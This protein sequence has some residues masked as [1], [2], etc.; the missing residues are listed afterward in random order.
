M[1]K[2]RRFLSFVL[3]SFLFA[4]TLPAAAIEL[5]TPETAAETTQVSAAASLSAASS[6]EMT[7]DQVELYDTTSMER[8]QL[9]FFS[10]FNNSE[11]PLAN[12]IED[13]SPIKGLTIMTNG[14]GGIE[15]IGG[16]TAFRSK[17]GGVDGNVQYTG[18][19]VKGNTSYWEY[20]DGTRVTG[21]VYVMADYYY[22]ADSVDAENVRIWYGIPSGRVS[23]VGEEKTALAW[24]ETKNSGQFT[25]VSGN[26]DASQGTGYVSKIQIGRK[27]NN[28]GATEPATPIYFDNLRIYILP[29]NAFW[30]ASNESCAN[31]EFTLIPDSGFPFPEEWDGKT[32]ESWIDCKDENTVLEPGTTYTTDLIDLV[33][34]TFYPVFD[35]SVQS[36]SAPAAYDETY[37]Q[38]VWFDNFSDNTGFENMANLKKAD[39]MLDTDK[40]DYNGYTAIKAYNNNKILSTS[41]FEVQKDGE[42]W[43]YTNGKPLSG[44]ATFFADVMAGAATDY[45]Y[46]PVVYNESQGKSRVDT[47]TWNIW[48]NSAYCALW[49]DYGFKPTVDGWNTYYLDSPITLKSDDEHFGF[50]SARLHTSYARAM[51]VYIVPD[52]ALWLVDTAGENR[53]FVFANEDNETYT[54]PKEFKGAAVAA[55]TCGTDAYNAGTVCKIADVAGKTWKACASEDVNVTFTDEISVR[56]SAPSG[57]RYRAALDAK[58]CAN[59]NLTEIGFMAT[60]EAHFTN[61]FVTEDNFTLDNEKSQNKAFCTVVSISSDKMDNYLTPDPATQNSYFNAVVVGVPNEKQYLTEKIYLR[62]YAVCGGVKYYSNVKVQ[63]IYEAAKT[64]KDSYPDDAYIKNIIEVCEQD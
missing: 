7:A 50:A 21:A 18:I 37:G 3:A 36:V 16:H 9:V 53:E 17:L 2:T 31:R 52:N 5:E 28:G 32:V 49:G 11:N 4:Q 61:Q 54:F 40:T 64:V 13:R 44:K 19:G 15:T 26:K 51:G 25:Y 60:R 56:T 45:P 27:D 46:R 12:E 43:T 20:G 8:G 63:S 24:L 6:G 14:F 22:K 47:V 29:D 34:K 1:K 42:S 48:G 39:Y 38:L 35:E 55:W 30:L 57:I 58:T 33:Q 62:A 41:A 10:G 59:P 23:S